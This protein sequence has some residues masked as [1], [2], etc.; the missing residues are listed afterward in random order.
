MRNLNTA[1]RKQVGYFGW[2]YACYLAE[3]HPKSWKMFLNRED[4]LIILYTIHSHCQE[5]MEL[6]L[7][8]VGKE[9]FNGHRKKDAI[10]KTER[11]EM[12]GEMKKW[13]LITV[14]SYWN[15]RSGW[16]INL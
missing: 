11:D 1:M 14:C 13:L 4:S 3:K 2:H 15:M 6:Y 7:E 5:M 8:I 9:Y 12:I 10:T 16:L